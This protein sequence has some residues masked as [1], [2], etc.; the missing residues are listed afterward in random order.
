MLDVRRRQFITLLS[1]AAAAWPFAARA[2]QPAMPMIGF[3][4]SASP[5]IYADR[6]AAFRRGLKEIGYVE[7]ENVAIEFR[8]AEGQY[9]RLPALAADLVRRRA[10]VIVASTVQAALPA[11]AA[12]ATIPIV[13]A[14]GAD[15]VKFGLVASF[16][17]PGG[18]I[19][20]T[21]WLG[22]ST[23]TAKRLELLHELVPAATVIAALINPNNPAAEDDTRE[24]NEAAR[25]L[26]LQLHIL[27]A[28]SERDFEPAFATLIQQRA[29][30]VLVGADS[31]FVDRRDQLVALTARHLVPAIYFGRDF[32]AGGGLMSY[33]ASR[34]DAYRQAG[35]YVGRILKGEKPGDLPVQ[36][37]VK[38]ELVINLKT[39]KALGLTVP[40]IMQMTADE[41]IE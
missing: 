8:W 5:E 19:T 25:A 40:L 38:I 34:S 12:T 6:V 15:P 1:G 13:F 9:D 22:G 35:V 2:Q 26:G 23:L 41:V 31:F 37:A 4:H 33:G 14:I 10:A 17:R 21:S 36:Q 24:L 27:N 20:G 3:L 11:K 16:N 39:A 18:N 28:S 29:G 7:G 32:P 30:A